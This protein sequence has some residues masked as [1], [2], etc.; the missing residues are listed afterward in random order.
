MDRIFGQFMQL[1]LTTLPAHRSQHNL[2]LLSPTEHDNYENRKVHWNAN[3]IFYNIITI[4][5]WMYT[6]IEMCEIY[7]NVCEMCE[8]LWNICTQI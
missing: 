2:S 8:I 3:I 5:I 1:L 7:V 6:H 4:C